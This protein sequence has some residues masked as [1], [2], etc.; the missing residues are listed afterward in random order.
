MNALLNELP[1]TWERL[2]M[3][4]RSLRSV[5]PALLIYAL[6]WFFSTLPEGQPI[7]LPGDNYVTWCKWE[8]AGFMVAWSVFM[9]GF[10]QRPDKYSLRE[11]KAEGNKGLGIVLFLAVI[12]GAFLLLQLL[13]AYQIVWWV[14]AVCAVIVI[15]PFFLGRTLESQVVV[16]TPIATNAVIIFLAI[17][18]IAVG[19]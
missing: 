8:V 15:L 18:A 4:F 19:P 3:M 6:V 13:F 17:L 11:V 14:S 7:L 12:Y 1:L 2:L 5:I 9:F 10:L 16:L